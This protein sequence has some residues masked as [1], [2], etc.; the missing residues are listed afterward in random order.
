MST[1]GCVGQPWP[2]GRALQGRVSVLYFANKYRLFYLPGWVVA[3]HAGEG[4]HAGGC[5]QG[6][7][8]PSWVVGVPSGWAGGA[9]QE[10]SGRAAGRNVLAGTLFT[11]AEQL[12]P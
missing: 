9:R 8:H 6:G 5:C 1:W 2:P 4:V 11:S 10:G 7:I 12:Q 3:L